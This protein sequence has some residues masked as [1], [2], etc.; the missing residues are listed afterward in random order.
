MTLQT[1]ASIT[2]AKESTYGTLVTTSTALE[3]TDQS[4]TQTTKFVQ[5]AGLRVGKPV[6]RAA[7]RAAA[8]IDAHGDIKTEVVTG[9]LGKIF[10]A[11][12]GL[13]T[14]TLISGAAYQQ[15]HTPAIT[16]PMPSYSIQAG[17]PPVGGGATLAHTF[18]GMV[19]D[20]WAISCAPS[21]G[22]A[23]LSTSWKG[24]DVA[25]A[26]AYASPVYPVT[27]GPLTWNMGALKI[28]IAATA[29]LTVPTT[30]ALATMT[31]GVLVDDVT[32]FDLAGANNV[33]GGGYVF[34]SAGKR[35]RSPVYGQRAYTGTIKAEFQDAT[36][37]DY[38]LNQ[39]QL[40]AILTLTSP[41]LSA[42]IH[43][44]LQIVIPCFVLEGDVPNSNQGKVV[45]T[46]FKFTVL[47]NEVAS[48]PIYLVAVTTDTAL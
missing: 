29:G 13:S 20:K 19:V 9:G 37:R 21:S 30:T 14:S 33:D 26:T 22:F 5:G 43:L 12:F 38:Y 17:L 10:N 1:D 39:T 8:M 3:Y 27:P 40:C 42:A 11:M 7:R 35:G 34:G 47:D 48:A 16:D 36:W 24:K 2:L 4:L 45:E 15:V 41:I 44:A 23:E 46:D 6:D 18:S 25:T 31:T 28:G 32:K